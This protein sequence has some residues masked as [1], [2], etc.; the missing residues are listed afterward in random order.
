MNQQVLTFKN[1]TFCPHSA[2]ILEGKTRDFCHTY[3]KLVGFY[4]PDGKC[5]LCG[6]DWVFK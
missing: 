4:N 1:C 5:L 2:F 6:M 3:H